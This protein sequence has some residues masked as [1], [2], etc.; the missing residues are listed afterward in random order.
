MHCFSVTVVK[1]RNQGGLQKK[2]F[3][4]VYG[5]SGVRVDVGA[6]AAGMEAGMESWELSSWT[7]STKQSE[8]ET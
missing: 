6:E 8:L 3:I 2:E 7:V 1:H 4:W 5:S